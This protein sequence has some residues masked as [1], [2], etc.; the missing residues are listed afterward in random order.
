MKYL[1]KICQ[2]VGRKIRLGMPPR[3]LLLEINHS[4]LL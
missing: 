1:I 2:L 3:S 4:D